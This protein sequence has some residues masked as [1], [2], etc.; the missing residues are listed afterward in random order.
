MSTTP[1]LSAL[2]DQAGWIHALARRLVADP[3]LAEDLA[4]ETWADALEQRP[5]AARPL[6][7]WLA[8]VAR[9]KLAKLR[10]GERNRAARER[11]VSRDER[12]PSTL[13]VVERAETHRDVVLAL[14]ALPEPYRS[15]LLMRF[16]ERLSYNQIARRS[17]V[18]RAAVNSRITRGLGHLR[19]LLE[20]SYGGDRRALCLALMP[21]AKLPTGAAPTLFGVNLMHALIGSS[22]ATILT[23][24]VAVGLFR[25]ERNGHAAPASVPPAEAEV[26]AVR[27]AAGGQSTPLSAELSLP[28]AEEDARIEVSSAPAGLVPAQRVEESD[29]GEWKAELFHSRLLPA[30]VE[31]L[32]LNVSSGDIEVDES[33]SGE[34][35]IQA[36]VRA[37]IEVVSRDQL[38]QVFE[39]HV[40]VFEEKGTLTVENK[41]RDAR[42]WSVSLVVHVPGKLP[43][44]AN[45]GSGNIVVRRAL[46][47]VQA[48]TGSGD[49]RL[50]LAGERVEEVSANTGSGD[51]VVEAL[52]VESRLIANTGSGDVVALLADGGSPG[53]VQLN[54]GSG[55][56]RLIVPANVVG[57][58][59]LYTNGDAIRLPSSL[60]IEVREEPGRGRSARGAFGSGGTYR[61]RSGSGELEVEL[62]SSLPV[63]KQ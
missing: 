40:D 56:L 35:Q 11:I 34:L 27:Q 33:K 46:G 25:E 63:E 32:S 59:D 21:L 24:S 38:T 15:T 49:V 19:S 62:G 47:S 26:D 16:F 12:Q 17:G 42:G 4:Q 36:R 58:F 9:N 30:S 18:T 31:A 28:D 6:R 43:L 57:E 13:E 22:A 61:L 3:H 55:D 29:Q 23:L 48:N 7:G 51:V 41:H 14:L 2:L 20:A 54:S 53:E 10:R 52:S 45:S 8:T 50:R 5:D 1:N 44:S 37:K 60:G 39:D